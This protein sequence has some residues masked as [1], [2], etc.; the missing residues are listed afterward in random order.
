MGFR[1]IFYFDDGTTDENLLD[2]VFDTEEEAEIAAGQCAS[3]YSQGR[4]YLEEA[5]EDFCEE[6]IED[7]DIIEV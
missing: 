4:G 3:D 7:W 1:V 5:G 6:C 2:E